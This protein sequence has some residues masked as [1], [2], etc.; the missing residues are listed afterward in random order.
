MNCDYSLLKPQTTTY[1]IISKC[2]E[3]DNNDKT[4]IYVKPCY[5][6]L[7][8]DLILKYKSSIRIGAV[9][10]FPDGSST[11]NVKMAEINEAIQNGVDEID[12]ILNTSFIKSGEFTTLQ[13][14]I[15]FLVRYIHRNNLFANLVTDISSLNRIEKSFIFNIYS[16]S[17]ADTL[18]DFNIYN[19]SIS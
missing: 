6:N 13:D 8:H 15:S 5:L 2:S 1:D 10:G 7:A 19:V 14:D 18:K 12:L 9:I 3:L 11:L 16:F 17:G 4:S